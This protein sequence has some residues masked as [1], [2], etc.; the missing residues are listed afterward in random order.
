MK[1]RLETLSLLAHIQQHHA[2]PS[3]AKDVADSAGMNA[4]TVRTRLKKLAAAGYLDTGTRTDWRPQCGHQ[5]VTTYAPTEKC[6]ALL[7]ANEHRRPEYR[8]LQP[9]PVY[10][11]RYR[12]V[13][14]SVFNLA[15][16]L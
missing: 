5:V 4:V 1:I 11:P 13:V 10:Q 12:A 2:H 15:A 8:T 7:A 6:L 3:A 9:R 14:N 16:G